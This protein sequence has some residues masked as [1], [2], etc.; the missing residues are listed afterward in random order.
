MGSALMLPA[1]AGTSEPHRE[2]LRR[3]A[4]TRLTRA[5]TGRRGRGIVNRFMLE[6][7]GDAPAAYPEIH[8]LT[9]PL[10]AK[11][12]ALGDA[13]GMNL[14]AGRTYRLAIE[15]TAGEIIERWRADLARLGAQMANPE[16]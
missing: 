15:A 11:A 9:A 5:F 14:W 10:R 16:R 8:Y 7:D 13:E 6:H 12:R 4:P 1:E 2:A 3:D